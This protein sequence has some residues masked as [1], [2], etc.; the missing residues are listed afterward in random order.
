MVI[1]LA[2]KTPNKT[3]KKTQRGSSILFHLSK[4]KEIENIYPA[5]IILSS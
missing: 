4:T 1:T 3:T 5:F 2:A